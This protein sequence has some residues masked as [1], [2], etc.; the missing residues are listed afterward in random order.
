MTKKIVALIVT[1]LLIMGTY[2]IILAI[3]KVNSEK[4]PVASKG[5]LNLE[6]WDFQENRT[7]PLNGEWEFYP[8]ELVSPNDFLS[9]NRSSMNANEA[10]WISVPKSWK[11]EMEL[12]GSATY[13]LHVKID[14][15]EQLYGIKTSSIQVANRIYVN[16]KRIGS[17]GNPDI[18][19]TSYKAKNKPYVGYFTL[20]PGF[21]EIIV[22][23]ANYDFSISSG[24]NEPIYFGYQSYISAFQDRALVHD[25]VAV[26]SFIIIGLLF[27][28]LYVRRKNNY[29]FIA[30]ALVCIFAA[31]FT[32]VRG[33]RI[34]FDLFNSLPF[35][36]YL[37]IQYLSIIGIS[38]SLLLYLYWAFG[39]FCSR[40]I[41]NWFVIAEVCLLVVSSIVP[42]Q[43]YIEL[44][45]LS[46]SIFANA[47]F[48]YTLYI[49][50][51]ATLYRVE[52]SFFLA[53]A[54][55]ALNIYACLQNLI[56]Y[57]SIPFYAVGISALLFVLMIAFLMITQI[58]SAFNKVEEL[59]LQL[60][61]LDQLK[62]DFLTRTSHEFKTPLHGVM[63]IS[64]SL[65]DDSGHPLTKDQKAKIELINNISRRLTKLV[66][67]ILDL[68]MLKQGELKI[69]PMPVHVYSTVEVNL[70]MYSFLTLENKIE[71]LNKVPAQLPPVFADENRFSQIISN[72]LDNAIKHTHNGSIVVE[73]KEWNGK[74]EISI[75]DTGVGM[76]EEQ[77]ATIFEPFKSFDKV[78]N[79][80]VGL[81]LSIVKQLV[82]LQKGKILV[83]SEKGVGTTVTIRLPAAKAMESPNEKQ[84][85][86]EVYEQPKEFVLPTP[87][88]STKKGI[89]TVLVA[90]DNFYNLK[91]LIELL[92]PM[93][94][95]V[96]AVKNGY[97]A[98][99]VIVKSNKIDLA[100]LDL[101]M[102]GLTGFDVCQSIR[103]EYTLLELPV[104]I[105]TAGGQPQDKIVAFNA[106]ANDILLKPFELG[107]LKA[108]ISSLLIMKKSLEKIIDT[109]MAFL[110]SQIKPHFLYNVLHTITALSY[111]DVKKSRKLIV[112]FADYLRGSFQFSNL[113]KRIP[114]E[115][116][117]QLIE[118]YVEIE[119]TRFGERLLVKY[120]IA[121]ETFALTMPP[122]L[123][124][125]LVENAIRHGIGEKLEGGT[126][127]IKVF[128][129][130]SAYFIEVEDDGVGMKKEQLQTLFNRDANSNNGVGLENINRRLKYEYN[131]K[132]EVQSEF[133][134]GTKITLRIPS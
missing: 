69:Q 98:I 104:L 101:M 7:I 38:T 121:D 60:L 40:K 86:N 72:L 99:D 3:F 113:E 71:L 1:L 87:Y 26:V 51:L 52:G 110:Q 97:E 48:I 47:S 92:E 126:V 12:L 35:R 73:A 29:A 36:L 84:R 33:E 23:V 129:E 88:T 57:F 37:N 75:K 64:K 96:I 43:H 114:F 25:W 85:N 133:G 76:D 115:K 18:K 79:Q 45:R 42:P 105:V 65:L 68:S 124:Q 19:E 59:S 34:L 127:I 66:F 20:H 106:G 134:K 24:I 111:T 122:L 77:L 4:Y 78:E 16:G 17:S 5:I 100:I 107:E 55:L 61:K 90:D 103:R 119:K 131:S 44:L 27:T 123:I 39:D 30:F 89:Y 13:R 58:S 9:H 32:S 94:C 120:D 22:Q 102:P 8:N 10:S 46:L 62:D 70:K 67:D 28:G 91:I 95:T 15:T 14:D 6:K 82:E 109:E 93:N 53:V 63:N 128:I 11:K 108:R 130:E 49:F 125:P 50:V 83:S 118:S 80:G 31:A 56:F 21:N 74:I 41:V 54:V 116:E 132:L 117:L 112:D 2:S 81:G